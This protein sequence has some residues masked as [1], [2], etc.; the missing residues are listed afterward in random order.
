MNPST[1]TLPSDGIKDKHILVLGAG[2]FGTCLA[3]HLASLGHKVT[4]QCRTAQRASALT[5]SGENA[6]YLPGIKLNKAIQPVSGPIKDGEAFDGVLVALPTQKIRQALTENLSLKPSSEMPII[7]ASKGI[8]NETLE[9]PSKIVADS[10][11]LDHKKIAVLSGPS[12]ASEVMLGK[13]TAVSVAS[14]DKEHLGFWQ[15]VFHSP[16]FRTYISD[17]PIGVQIAGACK[18][19]L[20]IAS[21]AAA[22]FGFGL[23]ARAAIVT[24]GTMEICA[25]GNK[26]GANPM[27]LLG[28]AGF[29]DIF[30]TCSSTESRNYRLGKRMAAAHVDAKEQ[31]LPVKSVESILSELG[32]VAEGFYTTESAHKLMKKND[33]NTPVHDAVYKTLHENADLVSVVQSLLE[34]EAKSEDFR[35]YFEQ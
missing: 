1:K 33:L 12:F 27:T 20:A 11:T 30:L 21:G 35:H 34:R 26:M 32:S 24:R 7:C 15:K 25:L 13:P 29:G 9:L 16:V 4:L 2:S 31:G 19:V 18:N 5:Q 8:E 3:Q 22:G 6:R 10:L 23:N 17:D 14:K 28:L